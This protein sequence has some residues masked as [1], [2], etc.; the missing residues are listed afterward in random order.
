MNEK[1]RYI[2]ALSVL[3]GI[4]LLARNSVVGASVS[5]GQNEELL[6][7]ESQVDNAVQ[8][9]KPGTVKPPPGDVVIIHSGSYSIGGFCNFTVEFISTDISVHISLEHPLPR[10]LPDKVHAVRQGCRVTYYQRPAGVRIDEFTSAMGT[11]TI[12]FA[13]FPDKNSKIYFFNVYSDEPIW[14]PTIETKVEKGIACSDAGKSG[15]YVGT[16][17]I[18]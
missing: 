5:S 16:F 7:K 13:A 2:V 17:E 8:A 1:I 4:L 11:S 3:V 18:P 10:P 6:Q 14:G 9:A 12:C 15:V